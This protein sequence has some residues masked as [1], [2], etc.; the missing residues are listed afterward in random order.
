MENEGGSDCGGARGE[1]NAGAKT[2]TNTNPHLVIDYGGEAKQVKNFGA[3]LPDVDGA[4][5]PQALVVKAVDL[6]AASEAKGLR[7]RRQTFGGYKYGAMRRGNGDG[8]GAGPCGVKK[9]H[10]PHARPQEARATHT[11]TDTVRA[12]A[13]I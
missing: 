1:S 7:A 13:D 4:V 12:G 9:H 2:Q 8:G 10:E 3:V 11:H 6:R 5:L